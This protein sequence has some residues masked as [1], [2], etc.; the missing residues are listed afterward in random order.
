MPQLR[1]PLL[2]SHTLPLFFLLFGSFGSAILGDSTAEALLLARLG[3]QYVP[4][5]FLINAAFLFILSTLIMSVI[6][7]WDRGNLFA[8]FLAG[9]T[10][11]L[12]LI[13]SLIHLHIPVLLLFLF[14]YAY[15]SKILLFLLFWTLTN[16]L[17][18]SR[19]AGSEFP[20]IAAGGTLG[21]I[22]FSFAIP[23]MLKFMSAENL[24]L[25]WVGAMVFTGAMF[26]V[27][28]L[29]YGTSF[30]PIGDRYLQLSFRF[31]TLKDDL[32]LVRSD[33]LLRTMAIFYFLLFFIVLNQHF[34]FYNQLNAFFSGSEN[35]ANRLAGFLGYF[36]GISMFSTFLLQVSIAGI[37]IRKAGSTRSMFILPAAF[38]VVF[39]ALIVMGIISQGLEPQA[40]ATLLFWG[41]VIGVGT[42]IAFFDSFFSPN[43]QI[44]F[45]SLPQ[46]VRGRGKLSIEGVVKPA[47]MV[48]AGVWLVL[49]A[50]RLSFLVQVSLLFVVSIVMV[51]QTRALKQKYTA[52]LA[53]Y[54]RGFKSKNTQLIR[55]ISTASKETLFL[56][57]VETVLKK[58]EPNVKAYVI[59]MLATMNSPESLRILIDYLPRADSKTRATII[60][61][62][63][64]VRHPE[65]KEVF[66]RLL[67]DPDKRVVANCIDALSRYRSQEVYDKVHRFLTDESPRI[68]ANA[69][70]ALWPYA[71]PERKEELSLVLR[72]MMDLGYPLYTASALYA[73]GHVRY[74][75]LV[76]EL[77]SYY[78]EHPDW[79][80][81]DKTVWRQYVLALA[82]SGQREAV[83]VLLKL[84]EVAGRKQRNQ[85][86]TA[87]GL[88]V[89]RGVPIASMID[90]LKK[91]NYMQRGVVLKALHV[92]TFE[93]GRDTLRALQAIANKEIHSIY[94]HWVAYGALTRE[95][96]NPGLSLLQ[97]S[98]MEE[99]INESLRNLFYVASML[100][101]SGQIRRI[102][103]RLF[104]TN[105]RVRAQALE[106]LDNAGDFRTNRHIVKLLETSDPAIHT[107]EARSLFKIKPRNYLSVFNEYAHCPNTWVREC[108]SYAMR[109]YFAESEGATR[110]LPATG[111]GFLPHVEGSG[112]ES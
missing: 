70:A 39:G 95:K 5:L 88:L 69:V 22:S 38:C 43:F 109:C 28:K 97:H 86:S 52:S 31:Q 13:R 48:T 19:R 45:S 1:L 54:L 24:L 49:V 66:L 80:S 55:T 103:H 8:V 26:V 94:S 44:F 25:V 23:N 41:V 61:A 78:S 58:E 92:R 83:E 72:H 100:D 42:R 6:D 112:T 29:S 35:Q 18:D 76:D 60:S 46:N 7:R 89:N 11:I 40:A 73:M 110:E 67:D 59:D 4:G 71:S 12:L 99:C 30:K 105:Q 93:R 96:S 56:D 34:S 3:S 102:V 107:N 32:S 20:I 101:G 47:A 98:I 85:I 37:V 14:S 9:H 33:P 79:V 108:C 50:P 68:R 75:N 57:L 104:H 10:L 16:D 77:S 81:G 51:L 27:I 111:A 53:Q 91:L 74:P 2:R 36:N 84:S 17:I 64:G 63:S 82:E 21:A 106:V 62:L 90:L 65:A 15:V 87:L